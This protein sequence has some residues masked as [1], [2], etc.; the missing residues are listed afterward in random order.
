MNCV[1]PVATV[2]RDGKEL[3][4]DSR[5]VVPGDIVKVRSGENIPCDMVVFKANELKVNERGL[6]GL[7]EK[8]ID[9]DIEPA[10]NIIETRNVA[11][12]GSSCQ[13]GSGEGICYKTGDRTYL[14]VIG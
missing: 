9:P 12:L 5:H 10:G 8:I 2:I 14:G 6:T 11:F 13:S 3:M 7:E 4:I 1:P